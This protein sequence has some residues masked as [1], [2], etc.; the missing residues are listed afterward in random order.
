MEGNPYTYRAP[1]RDPEAFFGRSAQLRRAIEFILNRACLSLVGEPHCGLTSLL[2]Y[3]AGDPF[4]KQCEAEAGPLVFVYIDCQELYE[5]LPIIQH[6][7]KQVAPGSPIPNIPNW[8]SLQGRLIRTL[9]SLRQ[10]EQRRAII[11]FDNFEELASRKEAFEFLE[12]LRALAGSMA[13][14]TLI[15]ATRTLLKNC[16]HADVLASPF[17]NIFR[18]EFV[19]PFTEEE[20]TTFIRVSSERSGVD[21][22]PYSE[23]ILSLAG[24]W[25]YFLQMACWHFY[26][27][28]Q[29]GQKVGD[30]PATAF[31]NEARAD[32]ERIWERLEAEER[33]CLHDL[34]N[35][36]SLA[37]IDQGLL[38][39][40][41]VID[42]RIF[43]SAF[44][45][46][47]RSL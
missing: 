37:S 20:A 26:E 34:A 11:L 28:A 45:Q 31:A 35:G 47:V 3:M 24:C 14:T 40:G 23:Q 46:Y 9:G 25:P 27:A 19:G 21:L 39:K 32:Y 41:Y 4:R 18:P 42:R 5:P 29:E 7:L 38:T 13:E 22:V 17:P 43:S 8:R 12:S 6:I 44:A 10:Q 33:Q 1:I 30:G 16:C 2:W 36:R 15:T